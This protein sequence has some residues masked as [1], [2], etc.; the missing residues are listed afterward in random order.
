ME[1]FKENP[2]F[3]SINLVISAIVVA[4]DG[5]DVPTGLGEMLD[6]A[7]L[8]RVPVLVFANKQDVKDAL[9]AA[10]LSSALALHSIKGHEHHIQVGAAA[11]GLGSSPEP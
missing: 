11:Q 3:L 10:E 5:R 8:A 7:E 1:A 2:T 4:L 9:S 6:A